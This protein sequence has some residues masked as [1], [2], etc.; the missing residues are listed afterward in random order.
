MSNER[1]PKKT[2]HLD[3]ESDRGDISKDGFGDYDKEFHPSDVEIG[4]EE[5]PTEERESSS[6]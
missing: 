5:P 6:S 4:N 1:D 3:E 2:P